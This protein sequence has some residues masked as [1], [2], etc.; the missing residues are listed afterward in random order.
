MARYSALNNGVLYHLRRVTHL[1]KFY[2]L[3]N[4]SMV[5]KRTRMIASTFIYPL[6]STGTRAWIGLVSRK[7]WWMR[8]SGIRKSSRAYVQL[9]SARGLITPTSTRSQ[10]QS[11][12][13][14]PLS[15]DL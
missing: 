1:E 10:A 14:F 8:Y 9:I 3:I 13:S 12:L 6:G 2:G 4:L 7:A 11:S 15:Y 5:D